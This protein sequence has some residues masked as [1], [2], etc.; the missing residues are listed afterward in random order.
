[1]TRTQL[2]VCAIAV[3]VIG[4]AGA[5]GLADDEGPLAI[6]G[7]EPGWSNLD[8]VPLERR[9]SPLLEWTGE[10]LVMLGGAVPGEGGGTRF[11][12]DGAVFDPSRDSWEEVEA[13]PIGALAEPSGAWTGT[14]LLVM[15]T[16]CENSLPHDEGPESCHPGGVGLAALTPRTTS[17]RTVPVPS[18][19]PH[20]SYIAGTVGEQLLVSVSGSGD[21]LLFEP[22]SGSVRPVPEPDMDAD[23][24][25]VGDAH[26]VALDHRVGGARSGRDE[27]PQDASGN[28]HAPHD[29]L[30]AALLDPTA[31][32][33]TW[34]DAREVTVADDA[35]FSSHGCTGDGALVMRQR[36][37]ED[38]AHHLFDGTRWRPVPPAPI[39]LGVSA[40][41]IWTGEELLV[42]GQG[43][44][45]AYDPTQGGWSPL[46]PVAEPS[47]AVPAGDR[48]VLFSFTSSAMSFDTIELR[49]PA[50][51]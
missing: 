41:T 15:G 31:D 10:E 28:Q 47:D 50:N 30:A 32:P 21:K 37:G 38:A 11:A 44:L 8:D 9:G 46:G 24:Y 34:S 49:R 3:V 39:P 16:R 17:W 18:E 27:L 6:T 23:G 25:C 40:S 26:L 42:W 20:G 33:L 29:V 14:E 2:A 43:S 45:V 51:R 36:V 22:G 13:P 5:A 1:V 19:L 48:V 4:A 35:E 7:T 12:A